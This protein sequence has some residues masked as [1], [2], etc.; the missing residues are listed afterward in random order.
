M[1]RFAAGSGATALTARTVG[2]AYAAIK[3]GSNPVTVYEIALFNASA[4]V[5]NVGI[6]RAATVGVATTSIVPAQE[7]SS[8]TPLWRLETAWSTAPTVSTNV[9]A[10]QIAAPAAIGNGYTFT[11]PDGLYIPAAASLLIWNF[12]GTSA[13]SFVHV[14]ADE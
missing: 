5:S 6:I 13:T 1:A 12:L 8:G 2:T 14:V 9:Y 3:A 4:V 11:F 7:G 10:R